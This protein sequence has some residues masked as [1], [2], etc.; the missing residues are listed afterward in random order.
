[1]SFLF[2]FSPPPG[3]FRV[4]FLMRIFGC[5]DLGCEDRWLTVGC[6]DIGLSERL[7]LR[8]FGCKHIWFVTI[9]DREDLRSL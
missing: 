6:E 9:F 7:A 1:M 5:E 3:L 4:L 8:I 2:C